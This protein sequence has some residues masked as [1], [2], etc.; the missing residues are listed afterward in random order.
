MAVGGL[1]G[2]K[3]VAETMSTKIVKL[4]AGQGFVANVTTAALVIGASILGSPVSTT[5]RLDGGAV[6][7]RGRHRHRPVD[8]CV[9]D[10]ASARRG[11]RCAGAGG[12]AVFRLAEYRGEHEFEVAPLGEG[13]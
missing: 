6:R 11:G 5:Q 2:A 1:V 4:N 9:G 12:A 7:H 8:R 10:D 3:R 13:G